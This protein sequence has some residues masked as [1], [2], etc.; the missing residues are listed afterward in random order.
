MAAGRIR[1]LRL[2]LLALGLAMAAWLVPDGAAAAA[3]MPTT[4]IAV[5]GTPLL[6]HTAPALRAGGALG[7]AAGSSALASPAPLHDGRP[8]DFTFTLPDFSWWGG[9][10]DVPFWKEYG[11]SH[12]DVYVAW[13]DLASPQQSTQQDQTITAA[14]VGYIGHE[15]DRR[16]WPS[17]VFHFGVYKDR[18]PAPS[19]DGRRVAIMIYNIRDNAYWGASPSYVAGYFQHTV[20]DAAQL[21]AVFLDSFDW[22]D[23][24]G[25]SGN[26]TYVVEGT[27]AHE[28]THL[29]QN[30][31]EPN[32]ATF[33][34]E[35][36]A[37]L[38][39]QFLYGPRATSTEVG[40]YLL[41]HRDSLTDWKD[42]L[43]DYG[44]ALLWE[45]Y[46]WEQQGGAVLA[47]PVAKPAPALWRVKPGH[48]PLENSARKFRDQGDRFIWNVAHDAG[49]GLD[50]FGHQLPGG[51]QAVERSFRDWTLTN[52][53]DGHVRQSQWN[54]RNL[55]L[56]GPDSDK[57]TVAE[58]VAQYGTAGMGGAPPLTVPVTS[59]P[60]GAWYGTVAPP[61][62]RAT[63]SFSGTKAEGVLPSTGRHEWWGGTDNYAN[64]TLTRRIDGVQAGATLTFTTWF[65][66]DQDFDFGYVEASSDGQTWTQLQQLTT[67]PASW[68]N[69]N[70]SDAPD[71]QVGGLTGNSGGWQPAAYSLEGFT[72]TVYLRFRYATDVA[73]LLEGWYI[74]DIAI[75]STFVDP[76]GST[77]GWVADP[78]D[79]WQFTTGVTQNDDW[80][81]D[82]VALHKLGGSTWPDVEQVVRTT[83]QGVRGSARLDTSHLKDG[84]VWAVV[85]NH[86]DAA[87]DSQGT[88]TVG[89]VR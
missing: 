84:L 64:H 38:S 56:G 19:A 62:P 51:M 3:A 25:P 2:I 10:S 69:I 31:N 44:D 53:L 75:G 50:A 65:N 30:D 76:V 57:A 89:G 23:R 68:Y 60:W 32:Q 34:K 14:E 13:D 36:L 49:T 6:A 35:G 77:N 66:I 43:F 41:Y 27:L 48:N 46:L 33:I 73:V 58:G 71:Y 70:M 20:N 54:Y 11:G 63:F 4:N 81:A 85:S 79:G 7:A 15:F 9:S 47:D 26:P 1:S 29:I 59:E 17:D 86:P 37:E 80:T 55:R 28:F 87:L 82:V 16:I 67:L 21:N 5:D 24:T 8:P 12:G 45:D 39:T 18:S 42:E 83:G 88:L 52:L 78:A 40:Q 72:G 22:K 74:D 61:T